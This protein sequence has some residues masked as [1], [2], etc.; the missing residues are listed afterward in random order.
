MRLMRMR[1]FLGFAT[2]SLAVGL[3]LLPAAPAAAAA[4]DNDDFDNAVLFT[5][6]PAEA[7]ADTTEATRVEDDPLCVGFDEHTIWY[8]LRLEEDTE[9]IF[10]TFGSDYD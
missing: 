3:L 7:T 9:V 5:T 10:D 4:P 6:L 2:A 1:N 8:D